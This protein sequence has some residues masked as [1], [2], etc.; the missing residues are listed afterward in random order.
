MCARTSGKF[1]A[2]HHTRKSFSFG[3]SGNINHTSYGEKKRWINLI[4]NKHLNLTDLNS[5]L[6]AIFDQFKFTL[7]IDPN[8]F[9]KT[10]RGL[11]PRFFKLASLWVG[12]SFYCPKPE[13]N[14]HKMSI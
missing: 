12:N 10:K 4:S 2:F 14:R 8:F 6:F 9:K 3:R 1:V 11:N 7:F 13:F 5:N